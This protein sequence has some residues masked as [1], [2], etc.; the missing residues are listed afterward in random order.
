MLSISTNINL[1]SM[2]EKCRL[3]LCFHMTRRQFITQCSEWKSIH[4]LS[5]HYATTPPFSWVLYVCLSYVIKV[6]CCLTTDSCNVLWFK[7]VHIS[8]KSCQLMDYGGVFCRAHW[9]SFNDIFVHTYFSSEFFHIMPLWIQLTRLL[10]GGRFC[11]LYCMMHC[12]F[13]QK[14][15]QTMYFV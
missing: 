4:L 1:T 6:W 5:S 10:I 9:K 12:N 3:T 7:M 13:V 2:I 11:M 14:N 8:D 15:N